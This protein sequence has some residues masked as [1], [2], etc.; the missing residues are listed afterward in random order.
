MHRAYWRSIIVLV[1][2]VV[3]GWFLFPSF[4]FYSQPRSAQEDMRSRR[5]P[6]VGKILNLGL[7]LQGGIHLL[8]ELKT[9]QLADER[10]ETV[11]EAMDRAIEVIRNR[12][13]QVGLSEPLIVRQGEKWLVVQMP[14]VKNREQAKD[15]IGRTALLEFR[16]V[17]PGTLPEGLV[18][19]ARELKLGPV[20][21]RPGRM[22]KDIQDLLPP[23]TELLAGKES[24]YVG[25]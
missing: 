14:G 7:D 24:N 15:L 8:L 16:L 10:T 13:D 1:A 18:T 12:I 25:W 22:P 9:A 3:S 21:L 5:N 6:L 4:R 11:N 23:G 19:K 17:E 2:I 20:D